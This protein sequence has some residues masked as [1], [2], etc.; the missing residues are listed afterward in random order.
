M[1]RML[2]YNGRSIN[3]V[4]VK[5]NE[6]STFSGNL[7]FDDLAGIE[8]QNSHISVRLMNGNDLFQL[9][10]QFDRNDLRWFVREYR[11][12]N[13]FVQEKMQRFS[14]RENISFVITEIQSAEIVG[15]TSLYELQ[16]SHRSLEMGATWIGQNYRGNGYNQMAKLLLLEH[17]FETLK[18]NRV[19]W[20]TDSLNIASQKSLRSMGIPS[21]GELR[22]HLIIKRA[23]NP[24]R[25]RSSLLFGLIKREWPEV[26]QN[27]IVNINTK[28]RERGSN[29]IITL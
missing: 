22:E 25:I 19:Q 5:Q 11:N 10:K 27:I 24:D 21:E 6:F 9:E 20:K 29:L 23:G 28:I 14:E 4:L 3:K 16:F 1:S 7:C 18:L 2:N 15:T 17:L 8:L 26:K 13:E 12:C